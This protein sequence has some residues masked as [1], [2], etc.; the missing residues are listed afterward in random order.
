MLLA[1][2]TALTKE[3][4]EKLKRMH[5]DYVYIKDV[6]PVLTPE[7]QEVRQETKGELQKSVRD[8]LGRHTF[9]NRKELEKLN[10]TADQI[11]GQIA[12]EKEV[13]ERVYDIKVRKPDLYEHSVNISSKAIV[14]ALHL[15][16]PQEQIHDIGVAALLHDLG[17][18]YITVEYENRPIE[19]FSAAD[20]EEYYK[21]PVYAYHVLEK[22]T[23][24]SQY[25]KEIILNHHEYINGSG[26][27]YGRNN[28]SD[29]A[30]ILSILE[31][32]DEKLCGIANR[33]GKIY[34]V[35]EYV[36]I[37]KNV[38]Y[39]GK[40][41]DAFLELFVTYPI[42]TKVKLTDG[43]VGII[44]E[45]NEDDPDLPVIKLLETKEGDPIHN[46]YMDLSKQNRIFIDY[47]I[48]S[49]G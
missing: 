28:L 47:V 23:W 43:I 17:L 35:I 8:I 46:M 44:S 36:K 32:F 41:L 30:K 18:R 31:D 5:I 25:A 9:R 29:G 26:Y 45:N 37:F 24:I 20:R 14:L 27:P 39:D 21:H 10:D 40:I 49:E 3:L 11:I 42:G 6:P 19:E 16:L 1:P 15:D 33:P 2:G 38:L 13:I 4:I 34:E 12:N 7:L 48:D 22:E